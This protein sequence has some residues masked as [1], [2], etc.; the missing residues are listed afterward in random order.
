MK[1]AASTS[2]S[3]EADTRAVLVVGGAVGSACAGRGCGAGLYDRF[4]WLCSCGACWLRGAARLYPRN[5]ENCGVDSL[6]A[7]RPLLIDVLLLREQAYAALL[8][9]LL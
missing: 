4:R 1:A 8:H 5:D 2:S 6:A 9:L 7:G 3:G